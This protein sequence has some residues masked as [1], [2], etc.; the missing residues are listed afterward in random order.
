MS[1]K[2]I[3]FLL[4]LLSAASLSSLAIGAYLSIFLHY[5]VWTALIPLLAFLLVWA[6]SFFLLNRKAKIFSAIL[7]GIFSI[8]SGGFFLVLFVTTQQTFSLSLEDVDEHWFEVRHP[9]Y[10]HFSRLSDDQCRTFQELL[11][12]EHNFVSIHH[13]YSHR[14]NTQFL[15]EHTDALLKQ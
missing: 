6:V 4:I 9:A 2:I 10:K 3:R 7:G 14:M 13:P 15:K 5:S 1:I 8:I 12:T 11:D